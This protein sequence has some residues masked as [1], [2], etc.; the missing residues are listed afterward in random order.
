M[1]KRKQGEK[2]NKY[3]TQ[4]KHNSGPETS[5]RDKLITVKLTE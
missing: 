5:M 2:R 3:R 1:R 4:K